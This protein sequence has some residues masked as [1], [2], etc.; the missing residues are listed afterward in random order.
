MIL[1]YITECHTFIP[2]GWID[3]GVLMTTVI[4][5]DA[6]VINAKSPGPDRQVGPLALES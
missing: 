3:S 1:P 2:F 4:Q 5:K 6:N